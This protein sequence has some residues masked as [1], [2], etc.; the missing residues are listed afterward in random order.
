MEIDGDSV[1]DN[2]AGTKLNNTAKNAMKTEYAAPKAPETKYAN[3]TEN[4][5]PTKNINATKNTIAISTEGRNIC[6]G[7]DDENEVSD[8]VIDGSSNLIKKMNAD[9]KATNQEN[10]VKSDSQ[11]LCNPHLA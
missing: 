10:C 8:I 6:D 1:N 9:I 7:K 3:A 5:T 11:C 4:T 2:C